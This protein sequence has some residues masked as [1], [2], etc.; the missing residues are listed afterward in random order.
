MI[1]S[2]G[3]PPSK[4]VVIDAEDWPVPHIGLTPGSYLAYFKRSWVRKVNGTV[5]GPLDLEV[6]HGF[7][8]G[9]DGGSSA[10][11]SS[12]GEVDGGGEG[13]GG[14]DGDVDVEVGLKH[15]SGCFFPLGFGVL[16]EYV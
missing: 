14:S 11:V 3:V 4:L 1:A 16:D 13:G 7:A 10:G 8:S 15:D 5:V 12:G 6:D 2:G 9:R